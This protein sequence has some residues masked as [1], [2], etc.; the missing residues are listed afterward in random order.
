[1]ISVNINSHLKK[2]IT[3]K[4]LTLVMSL[5]FASFINADHHLSAENEVLSSLDTYFNARN[6]QDYETVVSLESKSGTYGTNSDGSFHKP[7]L[8]NSIDNWKN[9]NQGGI[10]NVFYP[11]AIQI[12]D[13]VVYVRFYFEGVVEDDSNAYDYRTRVTMN[14]V[15]E[16]GKWVVK[17]QHY[18]PASYGGVH[19][20]QKADFEE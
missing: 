6:A 9:T 8:Q 13:D 11:E 17:T 4:N 10:T 18:S 15:K 12:S 3:M 14:W 20:T 7:L 5:L 19:R 1:M 2:G 16:D